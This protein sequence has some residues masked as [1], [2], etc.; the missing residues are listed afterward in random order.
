MG[1]LEFTVYITLKSTEKVSRQAK[2]QKKNSFFS[3][4]FLH[5][6]LVN[7]I[8]DSSYEKDIVKLRVIMKRQTSL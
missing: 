8:L 2:K 4:T 7:E 6:V 1:I 3:L 5:I